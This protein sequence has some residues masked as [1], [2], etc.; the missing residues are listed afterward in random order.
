MR[1]L[2]NLESAETLLP[3]VSATLTLRRNTAAMSTEFTSLSVPY[4][5]FILQ[6]A[7]RYRKLVAEWQPEPHGNSPAQDQQ[8]PDMV[9]C[10]RVR[11][12]SDEETADGYPPGLFGR[13]GRS[14]LLDVHELKVAVKTA[15]YPILK[16]TRHVVPLRPGSC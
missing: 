3:I 6:H 1:S 16:V 15:T 14:G 5:Q 7:E 13:E 11:P 10:T 2:F 4:P 8:N 12:M 9:V